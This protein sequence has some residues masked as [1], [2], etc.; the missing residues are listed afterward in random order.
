MSQ[1]V[2]RT[3]WSRFM[4]R[5]GT[6]GSLVPVHAMNR[7]QRFFSEFWSSEFKSFF[8]PFFFLF[9]CLHMKLKW[10]W[11]CKNFQHEKFLNLNKQFK[12]IFYFSNKWYDHLFFKCIS[13]FSVLDVFQTF[14]VLDVFQTFS[15]LDVFEFEKTFNMKIVSIWM[16]TNFGYIDEW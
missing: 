5:T 8:P 16:I 1:I 7:D 11:I 10:F 6:K 2:W 14:S 15:V 12:N 3:L 13:N 9:T 4:A